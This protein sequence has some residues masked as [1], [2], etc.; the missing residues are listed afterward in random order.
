MS[1]RLL[2]L[3]ALVA[4]ALGSTQ[5]PATAVTRGGRAAALFQTARVQLAQG[6]AYDLFCGFS[7]FP[8]SAFIMVTDDFDASEGEGFKGVARFSGSGEE[9][10][11]TGQVSKFR[12]EQHPP[13]DEPP[14]PGVFGSSGIAPADG[15][16][17]KSWAVWN[18]APQC[19]L[20]VNGVAQELTTV[21][22][23]KARIVE[24]AEFD[25]VVSLQADPVLA[26]GVLK[27]QQRVSQGHLSA[28]LDVS[29]ADGSSALLRVAGPE[30]QRYESLSFNPFVWV[31]E[32]NTSGSWTYEVTGVQS[33]PRFP[34]LWTMELPV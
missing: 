17:E 5:A 31:D 11:V 23:E 1:K 30:G 6:D 33:S 8:R 10:R 16:L 15:T 9:L 27:D 4:V 24:L 20:T 18:Q 22:A 12:F 32:P 26:A 13:E 28:V 14:F 21:D 7:D 29:S 3:A 19:K 25:G 2:G 34:V